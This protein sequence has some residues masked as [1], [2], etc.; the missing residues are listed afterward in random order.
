MLAEIDREYHRDF[1][2][3]YPMPAIKALRRRMEETL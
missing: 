1:T 3:S 2:G